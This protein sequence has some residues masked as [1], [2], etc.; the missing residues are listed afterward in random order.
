[1]IKA[2]NYFK[3]EIIRCVALNNEKKAKKW[4]R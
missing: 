4:C 2:F 1:M 3:S